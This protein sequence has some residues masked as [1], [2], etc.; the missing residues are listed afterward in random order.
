[1]PQRAPQATKAPSRSAR[2]EEIRTRSRAWTSTDRTVS[3]GSHSKHPF[4]YRS[5]Q[6]VLTTMR[7]TK[8]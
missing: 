3:F 8:P 4:A 1:V 2:V 5:I 6:T 7:N